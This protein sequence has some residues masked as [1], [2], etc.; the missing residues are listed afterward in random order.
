MI[1]HVTELEATGELEVEDAVA[2]GENVAPIGEDIE[3]TST[4]TMPGITFDRRISV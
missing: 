3:R 2:E 4:S 1:E